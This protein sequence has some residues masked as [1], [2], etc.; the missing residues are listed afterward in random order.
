[1]DIESMTP[2]E[3]DQLWLDTVQPAL[4]I[5]QQ[6]NEK[7]AN[8][9]CYRKFGGKYAEQGDR[10]AE[11][12]KALYA[13]GSEMYNELS[14]PFVAEWDRRGGWTRA[15]VVPDGHIH[16][17]TACHTLYPTTVVAW[18]P[19]QSGLSEEEIVE[20]AGVHACT[21]CYPSAPVEA[22]RAAEAAAKKATQCPGSGEYAKNQKHWGQRYVA[23]HHCG[24]SISV[25]SRGNL[26]AHKPKEVK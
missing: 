2:A 10:Y 18:L 9:T 25:T 14:V 13:K 23:C 6:A 21:V 8:A 15:Y 17:T 16:K 20:R 12:A 19:E 24:Q 4:S 5:K 26:R 22:L 1:M 7:M 11:E 3:I